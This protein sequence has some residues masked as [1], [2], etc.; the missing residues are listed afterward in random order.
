[1]DVVSYI[2]AKKRS[3]GGSTVV[4]RDA[5]TSIALADKTEYYLTNVANCTFTYPVGSNF[6]CWIHLETDSTSVSITFPTSS[7]I[8]DTPTFSTSETWE[9]SIKNGV[10]VAGEVE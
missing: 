8:G 6:E 1:M 5:P 9:I 4:T 2:L 7:Y 10:I 3:G